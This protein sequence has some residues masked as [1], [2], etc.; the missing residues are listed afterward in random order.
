[1]A[2]FQHVPQ[3]FIPPLSRHVHVGSKARKNA[4]FRAGSPLFPISLH[5]PSRTKNPP[6]APLL[7]PISLSPT[8]IPHSSS[9]SSFTRYVSLLW[10]LH[11]ITINKQSN[12]TNSTVV[13]MATV[14]RQPF[15]PL[16]GSRLQ[17]LTS[18]KNRQNGMWRCRLGL[19]IVTNLL[20]LLLLLLLP[21]NEKLN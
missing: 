12:I 11:A 7:Y 16:D 19:M 1:M 6:L 4:H 3:A 18:L 9:S 17:S 15:A 14:T 2:A 13:A 20:K 21:E 8:F 5:A 10:S